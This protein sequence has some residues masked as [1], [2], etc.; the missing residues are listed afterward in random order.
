MITIFTP[1]FADEAD[2]NAQNL[3]VKEVVARLDPEKFHVTMLCEGEADRRIASRAATTILQWRNRGNTIRTMAHL[4]RNVPD[5]YFFPREGPLDALFL[6]ARP[7]LCPRTALVTYV[8]SG[9][10][11]E[12]GS[13]RPALARNIREG[14]AVVGNSK[15]MSQMLTEKLGVPAETIYDGVDRRYFFAPY[16]ASEL[17]AEP[18]IVLF[19]GSLRPYKRTRMLV[20]QAARRPDVLFRIAG[21]GEEEAACRA[22][23]RDLKCTNVSFLGHLTPKELGDEMRRASVFFFPSIVEGHPQVLLQ[24][25]ACGLPS[26]AMDH[27]HPE[28]VVDGQN[29]FLARTDAELDD[30][31][32]V[33]LRDHDLRRSMSSAAAAHSKNFEWDRATADWSR[34]FEKVM[35]SGKTA[36]R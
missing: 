15:Y 32:T 18:L 30:K 10:Q 16:S 27:Y 20:E 14:Q 36:C 29:G 17:T 34:V 6:Q 5:I 28:Y 33:L 24:A 19:A 4:L 11:L 25:A 3:T 9:A 2:T 13:P 31:L 12:S 22:L 26:I 23:V 1:S 8:V 35:S 21:K 7:W